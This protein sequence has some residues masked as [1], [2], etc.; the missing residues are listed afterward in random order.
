[1]PNSSHSAT[2]I[3]LA[4]TRCCERHAGCTIQCSLWLALS[5]SPPWGTCTVPVRPRGPPAD[6]RQARGAR[7][8]AGSLRRSHRL[9]NRRGSARARQGATA[10][11]LPTLGGA[12]QPR[13]RVRHARRRSRRSWPTRG[14]TMLDGTAT[15]VLGVGF[16]G[17]KGFAGGFGERA[18][19]AWGESR[20]R[21][22]C[23]PRRG[24]AQ[25]R[26][27]AGA[28]AH[29]AAAWRC[30][31][32][33]RSATPRAA[34]RWRSS[35]SSAR[36][37]SRSPSTA[38]GRAWCSTATRIAAQPEGATSTGVPVYNVALPLLRAPLPG[39]AAV[40]RGRGAAAGRAP[41]EP[42]PSATLARSGEPA[43]PAR[44]CSA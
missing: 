38:T 36:A 34:S 2:R 33:R 30:C 4:S 13:L 9:R 44:R 27:G 28:P 10:T 43:E 20:S 31:T 21:R 17:V 14:V 40:P 26:V 7:G 23:G 8:R 16:A 32:T 35:R 37:G 24:G 41:V 42:R 18:L 29:A 25:A 5:A 6:L 22:S 3:E 15:E 39:A 1:M 11:K 12:R 19:Q